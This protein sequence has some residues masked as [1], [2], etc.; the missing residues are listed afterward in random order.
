[1]VLP[2]AYKQNKILLFSWIPTSFHQG[3][4]IANPKRC[5]VA[6]SFKPLHIHIY[7]YIEADTYIYIH[8]KFI[9]TYIELH[10]CCSQNLQEKQKRMLGPLTGALA[11]PAPGQGCAAGEGL[12]AADQALA[13]RGHLGRIW[14]PQM[15]FD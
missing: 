7:T 15:Y 1:M 3:Y 13:A 10:D 11:S 6:A 5:I 9:F 2:K 12:P 8:I 4:I 14:L